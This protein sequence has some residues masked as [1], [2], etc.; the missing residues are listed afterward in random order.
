MGVQFSLLLCVVK[1]TRVGRSGRSPRLLKVKLSAERL[2]NDILRSG[3]NLG[4]KNI[5]A[6]FGAVYV[7]KD[8]SYLRRK[9]EKRLRIKCKERKVQFPE[10]DIHIKNGKLFV[11]PVIRD[12]IDY[13]NQLF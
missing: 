4:S 7:N 2:R 11:G 5:R 3:K 6:A 13:K 9:E 10:T 12:Q 1:I 8:L